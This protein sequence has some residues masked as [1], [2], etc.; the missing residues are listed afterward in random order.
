MSEC[1]WWPVTTIIW[2]NFHSPNPWMST[3]NVALIWSKISPFLKTVHINIDSPYLWTYKSLNLKTKL[4]IITVVLY[5]H[6]IAHRKHV[7]FT[8][9]CSRKTLG[10]LQYNL[11]VFQFFTKNRHSNDIAT[12]QVSFC[13]KVCKHNTFSTCDCTCKSLN[14]K[15]YRLSSL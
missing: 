6:K 15:K 7:L 4:F 9:I 11:N 2:I 8:Y 5:K 12:I 3:W 1:C 13:N 10:Q 14:L